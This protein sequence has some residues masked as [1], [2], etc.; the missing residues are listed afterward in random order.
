MKSGEIEGWTKYNG[1][2]GGEE[3]ELSSSF[4]GVYIMQM[5]S[6]EA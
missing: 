3:T 6:L 5:K 4:S 2:G 1:E